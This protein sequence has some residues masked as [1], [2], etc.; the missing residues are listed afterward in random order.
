M[1]TLSPPL[2]PSS[3]RLWLRLYTHALLLESQIFANVELSD[4]SPDYT[5]TGFTDIWRGNHHGEP[6]CVKAIRTQD[7]TR[8]KEIERVCSSFLFLEP[9]SPH[10][11]PDP[12]SRNQWAQTHF[13]S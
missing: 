4:E 13:P 5:P 8:L 11:I 12:P 1:S 10:F 9:Y 2:R 7:Q 3:F 6:V